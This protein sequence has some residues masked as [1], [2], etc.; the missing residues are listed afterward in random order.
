MD[1]DL[2][3]IAKLLGSGEGRLVAAGVVF[4]VVALVKLV[5]FIRD[6]VLTTPWRKRLA[7]A[8]LAL[9][10]VVALFLARAPIGEIVVTGVST[11]LMSMGWN[12]IRPKGNGG[13]K[14]KTDG[15]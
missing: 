2:Q 15:P 14:E 6:R 10:P 1:F 3:A 9:A 11:F 4:L 8:V 5:P 13:K 12:E 7:A